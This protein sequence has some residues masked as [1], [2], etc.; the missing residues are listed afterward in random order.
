MKRPHATERKNF[1]LTPEDLKILA[2]LQKRVGLPTE[3]E[4]LR[5]VLRD[6]QN[7]LRRRVRAR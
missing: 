2:D 7:S 3:T 6:Y 1:R 5:F 4:T